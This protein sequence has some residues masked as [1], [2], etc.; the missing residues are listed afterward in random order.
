MGVH[1]FMH[2][3]V[4]NHHILGHQPEPIGSKDEALEGA[5]RWC[6]QQS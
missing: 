4:L 2:S 3:E 5:M 6:Q 1:K